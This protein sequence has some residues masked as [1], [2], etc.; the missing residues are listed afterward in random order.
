MATKANSEGIK[1]PTNKA[2][3]DKNYIKIFSKENKMNNPKNDMRTMALFLAEYLSGGIER[4]HKAGL[5]VDFSREG[6]DPI[7][8]EGLKIGLEMM[9]LEIRTKK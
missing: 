5:P 3:Y 9:G 1:W 2:K 4:T 8:S 7:I 6:L